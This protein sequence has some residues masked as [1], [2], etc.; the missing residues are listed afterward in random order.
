MTDAVQGISY[1][2][3]EYYVTLHSSGS[4]R[5]IIEG[6]FDLSGKNITKESIGQEI[7]EKYSHFE[8]RDSSYY[9]NKYLNPE[10]RYYNSE[11]YKGEPALVPVDINE[12]WYVY[13]RQTVGAFGNIGSYDLSGLPNSFV[14]CNVGPNGLAEYPA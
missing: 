12:G 1:N 2:H 11:P 4:N 7:I 13:I 8:K 10:I 9:K 14:L 3:K 5:Y 6:V